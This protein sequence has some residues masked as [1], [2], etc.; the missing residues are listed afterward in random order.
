[1]TG[2]EHGTLDRYRRFAEKSVGQLFRHSSF[3]STWA[4]TIH[5]INPRSAMAVT[6]IFLRNSSFMAIWRS[7]IRKDTPNTVLTAT[8]L[9]HMNQLTSSGNFER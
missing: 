6:M 5:D 1:M 8:Q 4:S 7:E 9:E 3:G 2:I